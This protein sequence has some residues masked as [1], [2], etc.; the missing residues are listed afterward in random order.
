MNH[1]G[2]DF[3]HLQS[4]YK[5]L[6]SMGLS[7]RI[8]DSTILYSAGGIYSTTG[9]LYKWDRALY[10]GAIIHDTSLRKAFSSY[11]GKYGYG[12]VIDTSYGKKVL[13]DEGS[14]LDYSSFIARIPADSTCI[15]LLDNAHSEGL[16]KIAED[17][18][19]I[20]SDRPYVWPLSKNAMDLDSITLRQYTGMYDLG[21][22]FSIDITFEEGTLKA[23]PTGQAK[24]QLF[25][26][27]KDLFFTKIIQSEIEFTRDGEGKVNGMVLIQGSSRVPG[28]KIR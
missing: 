27:R 2:F 21:P 4:P 28:K 14:L 7:G 13:M 24:V 1:S 11:S 5:A 16:P 12:W 9:D 3:R 6:G 18:Y 17:L 19:A 25:A 26:E 15:I 23:R 8:V 20:L 10:S 22:N